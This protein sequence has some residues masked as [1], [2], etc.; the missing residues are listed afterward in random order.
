MKPLEIKLYGKVM[1][2]A[3]AGFGV[4]LTSVAGLGVWASLFTVALLLAVL[5]T[6]TFYRE[7]RRFG[8]TDG[9]GGETAGRREK[10]E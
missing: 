7:R 5:V 3:G 9:E 8:E 2:V 4:L 10:V 1:F 6:W